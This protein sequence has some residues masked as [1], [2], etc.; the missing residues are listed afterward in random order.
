M[1]THLVKKN[2][3]KNTSSTKIYHVHLKLTLWYVK[4]VVNDTQVIPMC[5]NTLKTLVAEVPA[6]R[7]PKLSNKLPA[8]ILVPEKLG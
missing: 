7:I 1:Y 6:T 3:I 8:A 5:C 4:K 2:K